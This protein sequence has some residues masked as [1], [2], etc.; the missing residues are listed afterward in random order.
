MDLATELSHYVDPENVLPSVQRCHHLTPPEVERIVE[1]L[2]GQEQLQE[3]K[4]QNYCFAVLPADNH[5]Q[6]V[7]FD[8]TG[9]FRHCLDG[10]V[11][12]SHTQEEERFQTPPSTPPTEVSLIPQVRMVHL[13]IVMSQL[14]PACTHIMTSSIAKLLMLGIPSTILSTLGS[15]VCRI[16]LPFAA[17]L[18]TLLQELKVETEKT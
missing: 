8:Y 15:F 5:M 6:S 14:F 1:V 16:C 2:G 9:T 7:L 10:Q 12:P 3:H 11:C 13:Y 18:A 17:H 4:P